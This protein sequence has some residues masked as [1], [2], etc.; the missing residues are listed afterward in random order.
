MVKKRIPKKIKRVVRNYV[1]RLIREEKL[2][3]KKVILYGSRAKGT[4]GKNSDIDICIISPKFKDVLKAIEFLLIQ[5]KK[6]EVMAGLEP[7]G[8]SEKD[9]KEGSS[10]IEEIKRTGVVVKTS[11]K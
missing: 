9:F 11:T 6:E 7:V 4:Q 8:F 3:V 5:R 1:E 10:L 2:P